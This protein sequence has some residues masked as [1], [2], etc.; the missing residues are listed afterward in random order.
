MQ[1]PL[2][3]IQKKILTKLDKQIDALNIVSSKYC[4]GTDR[5]V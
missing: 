3:I 5:P 4:Q 1:R 2:E